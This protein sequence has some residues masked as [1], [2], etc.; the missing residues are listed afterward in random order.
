MTIEIPETATT[1]EKLLQVT[2]VLECLKDIV[3]AIIEELED[4]DRDTENL[5][6]AMESLDD[7]IDAIGDAVDELEEEELGLDEDF[8]DEDDDPDVPDGLHIGIVIGK[9]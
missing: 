4:N 6:D 5:E 3:G 8:D 2:N 1:E 7:A 9:G